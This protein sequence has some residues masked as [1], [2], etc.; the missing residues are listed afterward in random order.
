MSVALNF[1]AFA[2]SIGIICASSYIFY[3]LH[4]LA[5]FHHILLK[6]G[7][8]TKED[9]GGGTLAVTAPYSLGSVWQ[10]LK[11]SFRGLK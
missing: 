2:L 6:T 9:I 8:L 3:S 11:L 5:H 10:N 1:V 7:A 4:D